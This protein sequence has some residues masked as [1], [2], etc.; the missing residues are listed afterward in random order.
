MKAIYKNII[1]AAALV[2][3]LGMS[4][5][6]DI[7]E[8]SPKDPDVVTN[9]Q[10]TQLFNKCY[11]NIAVAGQGGANGDS[12]IDGLDGGTTGY[13]RQL[14]NANELTTDE[15]IC[16]WGDEGIAAFDYNTYDSSHPM[17]RGFYYRL[18]FG[19]PSAPISLRLC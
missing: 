13:V 11:A 3:T 19:V 10:A 15:A 14:F 7:L 16:G 4:S 9:I 8:I 17:L 18:N 12:D 2:L 1:P 5:C 6:S